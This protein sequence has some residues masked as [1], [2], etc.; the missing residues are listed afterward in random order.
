MTRQCLGTAVHDV[1]SYSKS[2]MTDNVSDTLRYSQILSDTGP[3]TLWGDAC[4]YVEASAIFQE[5]RGALAAV[6]DARNFA[7]WTCLVRARWT[8]GIR[9]VA[10]W[11]SPGGRHQVDVARWTS[12]GGRRQVDVAGWTSPGGLLRRASVC[13][14]PLAA[15]A[16]ARQ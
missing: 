10:R 7:K 3:L 8:Y 4:R 2:T 11:T 6:S 14:E 12:P 13:C 15:N 5:C 16:T 1:A 9:D